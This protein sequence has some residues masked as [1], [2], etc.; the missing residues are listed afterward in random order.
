M[1]DIILNWK[2]INSFKGD[3]YD[4]IEDQPYTREQIKSLVDKAEPLRNRAVILLLAS[5]GIRVGAIYISK[6]KDYLKVGNLTPIDKYNNIYQITIYK[7][8]RSKYI[9]FC[10]PECRREIDTYLQYRERYGER[11]TK[12]SP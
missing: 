12:D 6:T 1:N 3:F 10:S 2:K 9:T 5:S 8:S 11:I 4:V 7:K